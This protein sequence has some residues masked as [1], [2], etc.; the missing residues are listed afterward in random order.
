MKLKELK[1]GELLEYIDE[2]GEI[3]NINDWDWRFSNGETPNWFKEMSQE[4]GRALKESCDREIGEYAIVI[5][6]GS[7]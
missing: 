6:S 4:Y 5:T 1:D 3:L 2:L 7:E